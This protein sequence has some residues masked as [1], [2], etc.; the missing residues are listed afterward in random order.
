M[1]DIARGLGYLLLGGL[2]VSAGFDHFRRFPAVE[3][4]LAG[5]GWPAPRALLAAA[6]AFQIVAGLCLVFDV[7]ARSPRL[8]SP[9]SPSP[10]RPCSS[11]SGASKASNA[12]RCARASSPT[13]GSSAACSSPS[14]Q[15]SEP[16]PPALCPRVYAHPWGGHDDPRSRPR[17]PR[18]APSGR[19]LRAR[20]RLGHRLGARA[21]GARGAGDRHHLGRLRLHARPPRRGAHL[22]RPG[23]GACRR[24]RRR[25][26]AAGERRSRERLC[27]GARGGRRDHPPRRGGRPRRGLD[28]GHRPARRRRLPAGS[29]GGAGPRRRGRRP[30]ARPRLRAGGPRRRGADRQ[31]R[32]RRGAGADPRL[33]RRRRRLRLCAALARSRRRQERHRRRPGAGE[34]A[35]RGRAHRRQPRR[36]AAAGTARISL[37][38]ALAR[39]AQGALVAAAGDILGSGD[40]RRLAQGAGGGE[41][42]ALLARGARPASL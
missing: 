19:P 8:N 31:L 36:F 16:C 40:F 23:A 3:A 32:P 34:R 20:Q 1:D 12:T 6:S 42:D 13:S 28:R 27:R 41:I 7:L 39:L 18:P 22:A 4:M 38:S 14:P 33:R 35:G 10:R 2:F 29:R 5:R 24:S 15:A 9:A 17:L 30:G 11:T 25:H 37:G 21:R 26:P